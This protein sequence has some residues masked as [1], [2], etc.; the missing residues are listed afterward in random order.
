MKSA[1]KKCGEKAVTDWNP[2]VG[3]MTVSVPICQFHLDRL[4][5]HLGKLK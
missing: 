4:A 1:T 5:V 2:Y 3:C